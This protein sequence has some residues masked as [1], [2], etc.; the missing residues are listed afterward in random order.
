MVFQNF[1]R[2]IRSRKL[3][4]PGDK[5]LLALSGGADS[6][7]LLCLFL[8]IRSQLDLELACAHLNHGLRGKESEADAEFVR[9]L[10]ADYHLPCVVEELSPR[11]RPQGGNAE[12]RAREQRYRFLQRIGDSLGAHR[13]A[14]GHTRN[15]QAETVLLPLPLSS[16]SRTVSA[17]S[18]RVCP[19]AIRC[20][21]RESPIR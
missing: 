17:W 21:P 10:A 11:E 4:A 8:E 5:V 15:D 6:T 18:L 20:A 2:L 7:A 16:R 3:V 14:L 1:V 19:K 13:I 12:A 9:S